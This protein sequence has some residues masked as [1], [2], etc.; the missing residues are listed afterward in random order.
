VEDIRGKIGDKAEI[1]F[2]DYGDNFVRCMTYHKSKGL[3]NKCVIVVDTDSQG[4]NSGPT[5][6]GFCDGAGGTGFVISDYDEDTGVPSDSL[7]KLEASEFECLDGNS[8]NIRLLYVALT[9]AK[10][11]LMLMR[12]VNLDDAKA[13][14]LMDD[15]ALEPREL[16]RKFYLKHHTTKELIVSSTARVKGGEGSSDLKLLTGFQGDFSWKSDFDGFTLEVNTAEDL[17]DVDLTEGDRGE[18]DGKLKESDL[19]FIFGVKEFDEDGIPIFGDYE[20][21]DSVN[22]AAKTSVSAL[23][24]SVEGIYDRGGEDVFKEAS[25]VRSAIN[26]QVRDAQDYVASEGKLSA[27]ERGTALHTVMHFIDLDAAR[28]GDVKSLL[29]DLCR[30]EIINE[31]ELEAVLMYAPHIKAF[32]ESKIGRALASAI[33]S[34]KAMLERPIE[35]AVRINPSRSDYSLIQGVIDAMY[36]EDDGAVIIDYK[37][38]NIKTNDPDEIKKIVSERHKTQL[39]LY[40]AAVE[41]S[42]IH[43]KGKY[44]W[45]MRKDIRIEL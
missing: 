12:A 5:F 32:A 6:L 40:A 19:V 44:I 41:K 25:G 29:E 3:E 38:D 15:L 14:T 43:V 4:G 37:T 26:L 33:D 42:G 16:S 1:E 34:G 23:K 21:D 9:R 27:S 45:L 13:L 7:E 35:C 30:E 18:E 17:L 24:Q 8:E 31:D 20:F 11:N 2:E 28:E 22:T 36:I 39:D 10:E